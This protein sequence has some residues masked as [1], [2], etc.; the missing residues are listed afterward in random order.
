VSDGN[1][2]EYEQ[3]VNRVIDHI[4]AHLADELSLATLARVAAF[5]P[6]H[7]HRLFR[8]ITGETLFGFVQ[9]QR[10][11][12]AAGRCTRIPTRVCWP[13]PSITGS[14]RPRRSPGHSGRT[15]G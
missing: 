4:R 12:K 15:S 7:F 9:R 1:R 2:L 11:E 5:S 14:P 10:I 13:S 8:S 6:F 3:R